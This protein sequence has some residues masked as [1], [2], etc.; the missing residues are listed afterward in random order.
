VQRPVNVG[1][2]VKHA[3]YTEYFYIASV[4]TYVTI[5]FDVDISFIIHFILKKYPDLWKER[6]NR[7]GHQFHQYQQNKQSPLILT[8]LTQHKNDVRNPGSVLG[9]LPLK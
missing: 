5:Y 4:F 9:Q 7:D 8:E 3:S 6:L 2:I 1:Q